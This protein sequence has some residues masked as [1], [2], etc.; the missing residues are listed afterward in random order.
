MHT[1]AGVKWNQG[2]RGEIEAQNT[3]NVWMPPW[4]AGRPAA[5]R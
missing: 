1:R 2:G 3:R 5:G 4:L